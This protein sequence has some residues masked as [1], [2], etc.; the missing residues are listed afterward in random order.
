MASDDDILD[1]IFNPG[2]QGAPL[3]ALA[4]APPLPPSSQWTH[5]GDESRRSEIRLSWL[6]ELS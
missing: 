3:Q 2:L 5:H 6:T 1:L 4:P